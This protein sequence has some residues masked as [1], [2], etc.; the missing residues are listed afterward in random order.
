M[1]AS[2]MTSPLI[3][4]NASVKAG[5]SATTGLVEYGDFTP[6]AK[7][8]TTYPSGEIPAV[9]GNNVSWV[10]SIKD[11]V[12]LTVSDSME[13]EGLWWF[14]RNNHGKRMYLEF[15]PQPGAGNKKFGGFAT[16]VAPASLGGAA[17]HNT[18]SITI[19]FEGAA[20]VTALT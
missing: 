12:E 16:I 15:T 14:L 8:V 4:N 2:K 7:L 20:T 3:I 17:G 11:G 10:G 1:A 18:S 5:P 6:T 9:S 13:A 19:G